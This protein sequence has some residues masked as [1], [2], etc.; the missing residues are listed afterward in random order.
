MASSE[1]SGE[2]SLA[3][4]YL[5]AWGRADLPEPPRFGPGSWTSLIGPGVVMVGANIGGGEWLFGPVVTARYSGAVMWL[6][7]LSIAFQ[8]IYNL[9]VMRYTLYTGEPIFV[10]FLRTRPGPRFWVCFYLLAD[11]GYIWPYLASN[12]AVPLA[13]IWLG[14][15]PGAADDALVRNLGYVIYLAAFVPLIFGGKIY[16]MVEKIMLTKVAL[17]LGYLVVIDLLLVR[18]ET[19]VDVFS[20]FLKFGFLPEGELDW[21]SLAAFAA[22]AGAGGLSNTLFSNYA[23]DKGWGMGGRVGAIPSLVAGKKIQLAHIGK[24]FPLDG[25]NL[26]RWRA[27]VWHIWRDQVCVW[28]PG[29]VLGMALPA[30]LSLEF[31]GGA[32]VEGH[33]AAAMTA[34]GVADRHGSIFWTLTLLCGFLV[35][36][37]A[38]V[39]TTDG[40]VRRWT[41]VIWSTSG[42]V[43][44][45]E[46]RQVSLVYYGIM[47]VYCI[48]GLIALRLAPNPL[49]LAIASGVLGNIGLGISSL[50]ALYVN[51]K[52]LPE[53]LR[54]PLPLQIGLVGTCVF[55]LAVSGFALW[56]AWP[57]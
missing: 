20:G 2:G 10:G 32:Q 29:C 5:P 49:V 1:G 12:A 40:I 36:A 9:A 39:S 23:R 15:L 56:G 38:V 11:L 25:P 34:R 6:A 43:R 57:N 16:S 26:V 54:L 46:S 53:E 19:W 24:V 35:F 47:V 37:P 8:V 44:G 22:V 42:R 33:S 50:H 28:G 13:A 18:W 55:F 51:R 17:V 21:A 45:W 7:T 31:I 4:R 3:A 27:W 14:H 41:D 48:W 52:L 30:L